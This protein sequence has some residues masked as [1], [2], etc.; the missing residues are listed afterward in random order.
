MKFCEQCGAQ[1]S[2][3]AKFC[4]TCGVAVVSQVETP[5]IPLCKKCGGEMKVGDSFCENCGEPHATVRTHMERENQGTSESNSGSNVVRISGVLSMVAGGASIFYGNSL[6]NSFE[7][8]W[9]SFLSNGSTDPGAVWI[10]GGVIAVA[11]GVILLIAS[12]GE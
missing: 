7:A 8:Q 3:N 12:L 9:N 11:I 1:L 4:S 10:V 5:V 6:N 2:D